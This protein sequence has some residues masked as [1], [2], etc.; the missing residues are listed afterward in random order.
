MAAMRVWLTD[1]V[2]SAP[3]SVLL[4]LAPVS[5]SVLTA[6]TS[7]IRAL[8]AAVS[9]WSKATRCW[10]RQWAGNHTGFIWQVRRRLAETARS[11]DQRY[12]IAGIGVYGQGVNDYFPKLRI[13]K[14]RHDSHGQI[15]VRADTRILGTC[16]RRQ[17]HWCPLGRPLQGRRHSGKRAISCY[18]AEPD[19]KDLYGWREK[20]HPLACP[21]Q[22]K[23]TSTRCRMIPPY[24]ATLGQIKLLGT[25]IQHARTISGG[26]MR[27]YYRLIGRSGSCDR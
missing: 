26:L 5:T 12:S 14:N 2:R 8:V 1:Q 16:P 20:G 9:N 15:M 13:P 4:S 18:E 25:T 24:A 17:V 22:H 10:V 3:R 23:G 11:R 21:R 6:A 7:R 27:D 19:L